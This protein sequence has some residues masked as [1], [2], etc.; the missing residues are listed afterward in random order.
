[1]RGII[2]AGTHSGAGKTTVATGIM[3]ALSKRGL[4]LQPFKAGPDYIDPSYHS[5]AC[6][7]ASRNLDTWLL[8][9]SVL[10]ELFRRAMR[11]KD[12]AIVE[13]VMGLYDGFRGEDEE[14]STAHLAKLLKLPVILVADA[15]GASRSVGAM[16]LGFKSF[17]PHL[18][19]AGVILNGVAGA[20]HLEFVKPSLDRAG[21]TLL[22]CLPRRSDLALPERHLG[23]IPTLEGAVAQAFYDR[24]AAQIAETVDLNKV[25]SIAAPIALPS[26]GKEA[27]FPQNPIPPRTAIAVAMDKAFNFYYVDSLDLLESWGAEIVPFSP[28]NNQNVPAGVGGVYIGGGF[29]ELYAEPLAGNAAMLRSLRQAARSGLPIYAECGGLMYLGRSIEDQQGKTHRMAGVIP[30]QSSMKG[31]RVTLGYR[32][33]CALRDNPL[34]R[35]GEQVRGHEFHLSTLKEGP[36]ENQAVYQVLDQNARLEGFRT[37][38]VVASYIHLHLGSRRDMARRFVASCAPADQGNA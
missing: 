28:L 9:E 30:T 27:V 36:R 11:G 16:V 35:A 22:G 3:A 5:A 18:N 15:S 21:V 2:I 24:L 29:P 17:D 12:L 20:R 4:R 32:T 34:L 6:A 13:G 23:L 26:S 8:E 19:I 7:V 25:L 38:N 33:V 31:T 10:Q 37:K 14:G 1:M